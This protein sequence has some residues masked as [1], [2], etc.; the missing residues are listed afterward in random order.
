MGLFSWFPFLIV[1]CWCIKIQ[2]IFLVM[3]LH[4]TLLN[5]FI[6][7]SSF[8]VEFLGFSIFSTM[9]SATD[10]FTFFTNWM[11]FISSGLV[12]M[13]RMSSTTLSKSGARC[14]MMGRHQSGSQE[15]GGNGPCP[16][17]TQVSPYH[18]QSMPRSLHSSLV[19]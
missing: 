13:A 16:K 12:A 3:I 15:S 5:S 6:S 7:F 14:P 17:V 8:L 18:P 4:P 19:G 2:L 11:P 1:H 9:L 10:S